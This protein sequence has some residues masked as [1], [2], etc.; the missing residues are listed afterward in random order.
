[1]TALAF[2]DDAYLQQ[3]ATAVTAVDGVWVETEATVFYPMGRIRMVAIGD[4]DYQPCGGTHVT[5]TA[6][7]GSIRVFSI[8]NRG[9]RNRRITLG[10]D[11]EARS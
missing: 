6:E 9:A 11:E 5:R 1:M 10:W 3:L 2:L 7:I 4:I 8:K